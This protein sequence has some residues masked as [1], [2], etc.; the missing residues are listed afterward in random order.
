MVLR[1]PSKRVYVDHLRAI[2]LFAGFSRKELEVVASAGQ[3]LS[4]P[5][6]TTLITQ[7]DA[8]Y[9]AYILLA[10]EVQ[11]KRNGRTVGTEQ[12]G[13]IIGELALLDHAPRSA[14]AVCATDC[15]ILVLS[16]GAFRGTLDRSPAL[17]HKL[18]AALAARVRELDHRAYG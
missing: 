11:V 4:V 12:P 8:G 5:A 13:A 6:G 3:H 16:R 15:D 1:M 9:D 2:E 7:G 14:T 17:T 18:M 10:G